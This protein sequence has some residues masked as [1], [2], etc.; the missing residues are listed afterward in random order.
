MRALYALAPQRLVENFGT[1]LNVDPDSNGQG[2]AELAEYSRLFQEGSLIGIPGY[3]GTNNEDNRDLY[4][5]L[6]SELFSI[7][8][9]L[10]IIFKTA[11]DRPY[12]ACYLED[13]YIESHQVG[14]DSGT[15]FITESITG[16]CDRI[17]PI[18]LATQTSAVL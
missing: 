17:E 9:G 12:G 11:Q 3:G 15:V 14:L 8:F 18:Q 2:I 16:Q 4:I 6:T 13:C 7:P 1:P 5:N 10:C